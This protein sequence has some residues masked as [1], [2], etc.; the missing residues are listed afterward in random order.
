MAKVIKIKETFLALGA[1]KINQIQNIIKGDPKPKLYIQMTIKRPL[2]KQIIIPMNND[3]M[4]KFMK[5]SSFYIANINRSL[6][7]AKS[8]VLVDFIWSDQLGITVV[9]CKVLSQSDLHI[10]E[11]YV[12]NIDYID[13]SGI[14]APR[15]LQS[16]FYLKIIGIPYFPYNNLQEHL[17]SEDI[18]TIIK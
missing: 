1:K 12:K 17:S 6:R 14:E 5:N 9:A 2:R 10:I 18:E 11:N 16:K 7:N 13:T 4:A 15:L 3:N 8:E